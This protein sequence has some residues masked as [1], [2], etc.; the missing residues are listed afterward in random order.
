MAIPFFTMGI[1]WDFTDV[2]DVAEL[3]DIFEV[4]LTTCLT[5]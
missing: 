4:L 5:G 3:F 2:D 1:G